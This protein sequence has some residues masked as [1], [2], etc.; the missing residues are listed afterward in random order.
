MIKERFHS[1]TDVTG[2]TMIGVVPP[3]SVNDSVS[4]RFHCVA[5]FAALKALG[6]RVILYPIEGG[7]V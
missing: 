7:M 1:V 3:P 5:T 4:L 6:N 2:V